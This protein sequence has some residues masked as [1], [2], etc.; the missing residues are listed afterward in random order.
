[1]NAR[2][3]P[4]DGQ[5][6][7]CFAHAVYSLQERFEQRRTGIRSFEL[8]TFDELK[9]RVAEADVLVVSG[10]WR[11]ELAALGRKLVFIQSIGAGTDQ[12]AREVLQACGMR[13][14]S[15]QGVNE[16]AVSE[17]AMAL[18]LAIA[19]Q[20]P[21]ARDNQIAHHW[22][23]ML[24]IAQREDE[25]AGKTLVIVGMG[26]IGSRLAR[27]AKAFDM[28]VVGVK[29]DPARGADAADAVVAPA[30]LPQVLPQADFVVLT[31]PLNPS[32]QD[33]MDASAFAAMKPT[34]ALVNVGRGRVVSEPALIDAMRTGRIAAAALDCAPD[35]PLPAASPLWDLPGVFITPHTAG[36]TRQYEDNVLDVLLENLGRLR[37]GAD[38]KNGV[39]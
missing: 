20:L 23:G 29:R 9:A 22:R 31:C 12:F 10:L 11:N 14:A 24:P 21:Q 28:R 3:L 37:R 30:A 13:L 39:V 16:R 8:R 38:L 27:L 26:R 18:I 2:A 36:E 17:H 4:P 34:A 6:T 25:L 32:T 15:A 33:L 19:R 5:L 7:I 1:M 35:E